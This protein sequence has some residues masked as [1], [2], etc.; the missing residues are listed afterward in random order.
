MIQCQSISKSFSHGPLLTDLSFSIDRGERIGLIGENG[1]GK[2]TLLKILAGREQADSG[3]VVRSRGLKIGYIE[4]VSR[5]PKG[6]SVRTYLSDLARNKEF[7][8]SLWP[9]R[10]VSL[11]R[12][13][14]SGNLIK[15]SRP[16][17]VAGRSV[18]HWQLP[19]WMSQICSCL[20]SQP[21]IWTGKRCC[22]LRSFYPEHRV[23]G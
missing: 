14:G 16:S 9:P 11:L 8:R 18:S 5:F 13:L 19:M 2:S 4:Q 15:T 22:G 10:L 12:S 23:H 6:Q 21:T 3:E 7:P 1:S 20:M 17:R